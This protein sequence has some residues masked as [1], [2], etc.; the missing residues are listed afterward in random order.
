MLNYKE[1][2]IKA[3]S[4]AATLANFRGKFQFQ[5]WKMQVP[6]LE[7]GS[8]RPKNSAPTP[9]NLDRSGGARVLWRWAPELLHRR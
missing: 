1:K 4:K 9:D 5:L 3:K 6:K 8:I 7:N 2:I